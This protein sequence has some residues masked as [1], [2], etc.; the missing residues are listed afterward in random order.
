[1]G[2]PKGHR[3]IPSSP[4]LIFVYSLSCQSLSSLSCIRTIPL[5]PP[6][7]YRLLLDTAT[8]FFEIVAGSSTVPNQV[9]FHPT[10]SFYF[11]SIGLEVLVALSFAGTPFDLFFRTNGT[12]IPT[13]TPTMQTTARVKK[14]TFFRLSLGLHTSATGACLFHGLYFFL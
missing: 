5:P 7:I 10:N 4:R 2:L 9:C 12:V 8:V 13:A 11:C 3:S 14:T 6:T 1:M